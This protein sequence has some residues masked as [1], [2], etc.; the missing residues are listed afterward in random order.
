MLDADDGDTLTFAQAQV[1]AAEWLREIERGAG[2]VME[3]ITVA[4][5]MEGYVTDY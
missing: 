1:R 4:E 2:R 5:A 3:P